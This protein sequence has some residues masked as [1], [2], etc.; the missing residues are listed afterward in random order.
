MPPLGGD[1]EDGSP[2]RPELTTSPTP[3]ALA[4]YAS[5]NSLKHNS[6]REGETA[7]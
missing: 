1:V 2:H 5:R 4:E 6:K 3:F 7:R